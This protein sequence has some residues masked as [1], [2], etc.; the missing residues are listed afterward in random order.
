MLALV[1]VYAVFKTYTLKNGGPPVA[2][3]LT[4]LP[5]SAQL[6]LIN[7]EYFD[8]MGVVFTGFLFMVTWEFS[9]GR[10]EWMAVLAVGSAGVALGVAAISHGAGQDGGTSRYAGW[11]WTAFEATLAFVCAGLCAIWVLRLATRPT[12]S[13]VQPASRALKTATARWAAG[14]LFFTLVVI[15]F[16]THPF[17]K[18]GYYGN[19]RITVSYLYLAYLIIGLP[20]AFVTNWL[21][22]SMGE[23]RKD[24][25]FMIL[26]ILRAAFQRVRGGKSGRF[27]TVVRN[28]AT[29]SV[30]RDLG[31]KF[32][33]VPLM[34]TFIFTECGGFFRHFPALLA[35]AADFFTN[36]SAF[37]D[38]AFIPGKPNRLSAMFNQFYFSAFH[39]IFVM[40]VGL[41]LVGYICTA[42]WLDN[43]SKSVDPTL[44]GWMIALVCYP[45]FNSVT[46]GYMP[47]NRSFGDMP[48]LAFTQY[49]VIDATT[50]LALTDALDVTLKIITLAAF[51]I[52]VWATM[53][54]GL[55]F[56]NLTNRG[57]IA[58]GP[59][60]WIRH[61]AYVSKN[62]AWWAE[63]IR[64]FS[65][66]WQIIFLTA[67]NY[68]YYLRA[69]TEER[70]LLRDPD[71]RAY[72][73]KV[74]HRFIPGL[75]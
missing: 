38:G 21:R 2:D 72:R 31:V 64:S 73:E 9:R 7:R 18:T 32:F 70:H 8:I 37:F 47:Y 4:F 35:S 41:S 54:F 27:S 44:S 56:S 24:P 52:Y 26:L 69:V 48:Y 34:V 65:S 15:I 51:T 12:Q 67:W 75:F 59:Y 36:P 40:D 11:D 17:Y 3:C 1:A 20:Y 46:T 22:K 62:I 63:N 29:L 13:P 68:I 30:L 5:K 28:R 14:L 50:A 43:K 42:R 71:Y 19:W 61:P 39:G 16:L 55:R 6:A 10:A 23:D 60:A 25:G 49:S 66:P 45:P 57:I 58:R 33:F 74:R 53:A